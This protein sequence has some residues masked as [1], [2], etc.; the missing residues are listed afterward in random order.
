MKSFLVTHWDEILSVLAILVVL[1]PIVFNAF[2]NLICKLH[3]VF[4]DKHIV[5]NVTGSIVEGINRIDV[6]GCVLI[7]ALNIFIY[8]KSF[9]PYRISCKLKM[10][11]G[12]KICASMYEGDIGYSDTSAPPKYH[13][14]IFEEKYNMNTN[15]V[16][17]TNKDNI[18]IIPFFL[19]DVNLHNFENVEKIIIKLKGRVIT[20]RI[21]LKTNLCVNNRFLPKFDKI[22]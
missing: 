2:L 8:Q 17:E 18:R 22:I 10:K 13:Q 15:R 1:V 6:T 12:G 4:L 11:N 14:F 9:F 7:L 20:K 19:T 3:V 5:Y 16:I 21:V